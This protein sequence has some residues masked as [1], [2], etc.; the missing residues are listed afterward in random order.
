MAHIQKVALAGA[1]GALGPHMLKALLDLQFDVTVL[2]RQGSTSKLPDSIK[3]IVVDYNNVPSLV[4]ALKGQDA[5]ISTLAASAV[6]LQINLVDAAIEANVKRFI[7]SEY[8]CDMRNERA[9]NLPFFAQK[10]VVRAYLEEKSQSTSLTYSY[11][12]N[13]VF[14]DY[15]VSNGLLIDLKNKKLDLMDDGNRLSTVTPLSHVARATVAVLKHPEETKNRPVL[16][17]GAQLSQRKLLELSQRVVGSEGWQITEVSSEKGEEEAWRNFKAAP[18]DVMGWI[19]GFLRRAVYG[20]GYG[21][22]LSQDNDNEL[23]GLKVLTDDEILE[24]IKFASS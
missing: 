12:Y 7:P 15:G 16:V 10:N 8:G 21:G 4:A 17:H 6:P 18:Q 20:E 1:T 22:D 14:L 5:V 19:L 9:R 23:L 2:V 3:T 13:V 24:I 11:I